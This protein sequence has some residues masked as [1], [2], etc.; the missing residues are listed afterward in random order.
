MVTWLGV[1]LSVVHNIAVVAGVQLDGGLEHRIDGKME[2]DDAVAAVDALHLDM[3]VA[4]LGEFVASQWERLV[5]AQRLIHVGVVGGLDGQ[6]EVDHAVALVEGGQRVGVEARQGELLPLEGVGAV[7]ADFRKD[8]PAV[9][10]MDGQL[11]MDDA[12]AL[13]H[14][15]EGMGIGARQRERLSEEDVG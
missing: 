3:I 5:L 12:V 15:G 2:V 4:R 6:L 11:K 1:R 7:V 14:G 13:V 8:C 9:G 10:G